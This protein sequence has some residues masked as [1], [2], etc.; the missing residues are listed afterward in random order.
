MAVSL[1]LAAAAVAAQDV[2]AEV[3]A[4]GEGLY[5]ENCAHC[6]QA[7]GR[8]DGGAAPPLAVNSRLGNEVRVITQVLQGGE[9]M[10]G[11]AFLLSDSEIAAVVT[12]IRNSWE[13]E[14][15]P[16]AEDQVAAIR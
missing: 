2:S 16:V 10:P 9:Y 3:M 8:G 7:T 1:G 4:A 12:Y 13:N 11:F 6:H 14:Y 5:T 15:G